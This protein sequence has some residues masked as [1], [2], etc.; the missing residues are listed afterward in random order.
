MRRMSK[1]NID[2]LKAYLKKQKKEDDN[3]KQHSKESK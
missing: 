3:L 2:K 1:K